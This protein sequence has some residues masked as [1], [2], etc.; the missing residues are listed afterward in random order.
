MPS[1]PRSLAGLAPLLALALL[2]APT[3]ADPLLQKLTFEAMSSGDDEVLQAVST[4]HRKGFL[5]TVV[6]VVREH[7][8]D[9]DD[10]V[11]RT[12]QRI[13]KVATAWIGQSFETKERK[14]TSTNITAIDWKPGSSTAT[15]YFRY[16]L[17]DY[18]G[19]INSF[20]K[21]KG[22]AVLNVRTWQVGKWKQNRL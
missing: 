2:A 9:Q 16:Q 8:Q 3:R 11:A 13:R 10:V 15:V 1:I 5:Q 21:Y 4:L 12:A 20:P 14:I 18:S 22:W 6:R 7:L 19:L 17:T